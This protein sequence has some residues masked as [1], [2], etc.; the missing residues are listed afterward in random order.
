[1]GSLPWLGTW[2]AW[3]TW[4]DGTWGLAGSR[5]AW[6]VA[7]L[8]PCAPACCSLPHSIAA[9]SLT[10]IWEG[11]RVGSTGREQASAKSRV[12]SL[13][14]WHLRIVIPVAKGQFQRN[15]SQELGALGARE[16]R[17]GAARICGDLS[18]SSLPIGS[19]AKEGAQAR[20]C[21]GVWEHWEPQSRSSLLPEF[22]GWHS[23]LPARSKGSGCFVAPGLAVHGEHVGSKFGKGRVGGARQARAG[24][25]REQVRL[26]SWSGVRIQLMINFVSWILGFWGIFIERCGST[27]RLKY[28]LQ[29]KLSIRANVVLVLGFCAEWWGSDLGCGCLL[30]YFWFAH[31]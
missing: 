14:S 28:Y 6:V 24:A 2:V 23:P 7:G 17:W 22:A 13:P 19:T 30:S 1:M 31:F 5:W 9:P 15:V 16:Q 27:F 10:R 21:T 25:T 18:R 20:G 8:L 29:L 12:C 4:V 26:F 11:A 3:H